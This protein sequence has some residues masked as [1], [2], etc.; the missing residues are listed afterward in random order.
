MKKGLFL[1]LAIITLG[2][3][4]VRADIAAPVLADKEIRVQIKDNA[5]PKVVADEIQKIDGVFYAD[6]VTPQRGETCK[7]CEECKTTSCDGISENDIKN[8]RTTTY[9]IYI[10]LGVLVILMIIVIALLI[11]KRKKDSKKDA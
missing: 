3:I 5:D 2:T 7:P 6:V 1:L 8:L 11:S 9:L 4:N 10:T